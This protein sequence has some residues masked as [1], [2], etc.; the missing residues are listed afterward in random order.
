MIPEVRFFVWLNLKREDGDPERLYRIDE[1]M[2]KVDIPFVF[3]NVRCSG[4]LVV[5]YEKVPDPEEVHPVFR[6]EVR[7]DQ[8]LLAKITYQ[9]EE[10]VKRNGELL[11][12]MVKSELNLPL[13]DEDVT[14]HITLREVPEKNMIE[15]LSNLYARTLRTVPF[16]N[17]NEV[18]RKLVD[19]FVSFTK[20][21]VE[22]SVDVVVEQLNRKNSEG[23]LLRERFKNLGF[24]VRSIK[25]GWTE[26]RHKFEI[27][28]S[29]VDAKIYLT[30]GPG[31]PVVYDW[32][33]ESWT[34]R[35]FLL[36]LTTFCFPFRELAYPTNDFVKI[37][38]VMEEVV[39]NEEVPVSVKVRLNGLKDRYG[40]E[41][42][43]EIELVG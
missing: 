33:V 28:Y 2:V 31:R 36:F 39:K 1:I 5:D 6:N 16:P 8:D 26:V 11:L 30:S 37:E 7:F 38:E 10:K 29:D 13:G 41:V 15:I 22:S 17:Y 23:E 4:V 9:V 20:N 42:S 35:Q 34:A 40:R 24:S 32:M 12:D 27:L 25:I 21:L 19:R 18:V 14:A 43:K 3:I